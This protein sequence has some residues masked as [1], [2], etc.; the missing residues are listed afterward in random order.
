MSYW[1]R[2][3]DASKLPIGACPE[4]GQARSQCAG[5]VS[6]RRISVWAANLPRCTTPHCRNLAAAC[7]AGTLLDVPAPRHTR[8]EVQN[9]YR[10]IRHGPWVRRTD[11]LPPTNTEISPALLEGLRRY[12]LLHRLVRGTNQISTVPSRPRC[13]TCYLALMMPWKAASETADS[14]GY[15]RSICYGTLQLDASRQSAWRVASN[16]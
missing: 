7:C 13:R 11:S 12:R 4:Q 2:M 15:V 6:T 10:T 8:R 9:D 3:N 1:A 14:G 5:E 16:L